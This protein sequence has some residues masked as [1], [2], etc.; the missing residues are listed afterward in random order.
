[1]TSQRQ[2]RHCCPQQQIASVV[3]GLRHTLHPGSGQP[4]PEY[5]LR[6]TFHPLL[7]CPDGSYLALQHDCHID[8]PIDVLGL[9]NLHFCC[10]GWRRLV[11]DHFQNRCW[12][13]GLMSQYRG[14]PRPP[15]F[16]MD[17]FIS[18]TPRDTRKRCASHHGKR[19]SF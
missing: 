2:Q 14:M 19:S 11:Q 5:R 10:G 3:N 13:F 15:G 18:S 9:C 7:N 4:T 1:M 16:T 12:F 17:K 6:G 8:D